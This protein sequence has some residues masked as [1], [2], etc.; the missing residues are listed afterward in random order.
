[1][2]EKTGNADHS[3]GESGNQHAEV[4]GNENHDHEE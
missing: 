1:M 2:A 4:D 3:S